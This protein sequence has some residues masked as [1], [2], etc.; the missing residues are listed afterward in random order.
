MNEFKIK[1]YTV[2]VG[3]VEV[4]DYYLTYERAERIYQEYVDQGYND[5]IIEKI[6]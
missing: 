5:V 6:K 4:N 1:N 3:G 2:W